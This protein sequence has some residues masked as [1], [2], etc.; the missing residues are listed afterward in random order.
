VSLAAVS[1]SGSAAKYIPLLQSM[2][3]SVSFTPPKPHPQASAWQQRITGK[4]LLY[5]KTEGGGTTRIYI[6]LYPNGSY[7]YNYQSS[8]ASGGFSD[9][10]YADANKDEGTWKLVARGDQV[11]L[12]GISSKTG[13]TTEFLLGPAT[14]SSEVMIG[15][16]KYFITELP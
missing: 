6:D 5:L 2:A 12:L 1:Q 9:F 10:S 14:K 3:A 7:F 16:R 13:E 8:Y 4:R 11:I 15:N